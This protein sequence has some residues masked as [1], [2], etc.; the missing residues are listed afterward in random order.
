[1]GDLSIWHWIVVFLGIALVVLFYLSV[2]NARRRRELAAAGI[3]TRVSGVGGWLAFYTFSILLLLPLRVL[4]AI[5]QNLGALHQLPASATGVRTALLADMAVS[6]GLLALGLWAA[7]GLLRLRPNALERN[8]H[9]LL[10][11]LVAVV[12]WPFLALTIA[13]LPADATKSSTADL[14]SGV[15]GGTLY[16]LIWSTYFKR[17]ERVRNTFGEGRTASSTTAAANSG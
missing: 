4:A 5:G 15:V 6:L 9:Y 1:M 3:T 13:D 10:G 7:I 14:V 17:S 8:K 2:R 11:S 16:Y 12:L